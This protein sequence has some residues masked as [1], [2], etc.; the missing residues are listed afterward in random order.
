MISFHYVSPTKITYKPVVSHEN[1]LYP[2]PSHYSQFDHPN[3]VWWR[4]WIIKLLIMYWSPN[5]CYLYLLRSIY[6][7]ER[8]L[9]KNHS[10][11]FY[12]NVSVQDWHSYKTK[13][14]I[15]VHY[16][17]IFI[18]FGSNPD[19]KSFRTK[20]LRTVFLN[21]ISFPKGCFQIFK[22]FHLSK[23]LLWIFMSSSSIP[24]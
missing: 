24:I 1:L 22:I 23:E 13:D 15:I 6:S 12:L 4:V 7:P 5:P 2:S 8:P 21:R 20:W 10:L 16:F 19:D 11:C 9:L 3:N 18:L 17:L 14:K